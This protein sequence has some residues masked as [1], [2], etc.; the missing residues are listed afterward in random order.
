MLAESCG[1]PGCHYLPLLRSR[2]GAVECASCGPVTDSPSPAVASAWPS[3]AEK[4]PEEEEP[5]E[6][7][8]EEDAEDVAAMKAAMADIASRRAR[9]DNNEKSPKELKQD[10]LSKML[11]SGYAMMA[12]SCPKESCGFMPLLKSRGGVVE[13]AGCGVVGRKRGEEEVEAVGEK[14]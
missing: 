12:D 9:Q 4:E 10:K 1:N 14:R 5:E 11:L 13:C 7:E 8:E 6:E 3:A 2:S